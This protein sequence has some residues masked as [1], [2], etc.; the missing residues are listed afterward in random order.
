RAQ[1]LDFSERIELTLKVTRFAQPESISLTKKA[2]L[3]DN[4]QG[5]ATTTKICLRGGKIFNTISAHC[6]VRETAFAFSVTKVCLYPEIK[7]PTL[8]RLFRG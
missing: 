7:K 8:S 1:S 4:L 6:T 3:S 2:K 5:L